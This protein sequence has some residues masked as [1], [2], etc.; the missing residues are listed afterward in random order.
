MGEHPVLVGVAGPLAGQR[1]AVPDEGLEIG[2]SDQNHVVLDTEG[3]S[4]FHAKLSWNDGT[5]WLQD[6]GSRNGVFVNGARVGGHRALKVGDEIAFGESQ[7]V[8]QWNDH[9]PEPEPS[10]TTADATSARKPWYWP[11]G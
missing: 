1:F 10:A 6:V 11:F 4:R 5:L 2:R 9:D 8:L 7:F 3:V